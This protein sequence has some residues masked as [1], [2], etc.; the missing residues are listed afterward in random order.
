MRTRSTLVALALT[1]IATVALSAQ[2]ATRPSDLQGLWTNGTITPLQ[3]P[4]NLAAKLVFSELEAAEYERT[5]LGEFR[6]NFPPEI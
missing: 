3:R 6:K 5:W 4:A 1:T 2:R